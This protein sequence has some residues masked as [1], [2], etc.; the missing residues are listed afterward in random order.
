[1]DI[2]LRQLNCSAK[3]TYTLTDHLGT[4]VH[5]IIHAIIQCSAMHNAVV[6]IQLKL[7]LMFIKHQNEGKCNHGRFDYGMFSWVENFR[8][9]WL[10][11]PC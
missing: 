7:L 4:P 8:K 1:M 3:A 5:L 11:M 10:E 6:Q 9:C 2:I